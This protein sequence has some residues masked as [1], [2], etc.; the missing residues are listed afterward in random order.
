MATQLFLSTDECACAAF[1]E[2][3]VLSQRSNP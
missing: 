3:V 2:D 1:Y